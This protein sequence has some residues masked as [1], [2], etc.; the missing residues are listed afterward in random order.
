MNSWIASFDVDRTRFQSVAVMC[1][2]RLRKVG[3]Q[4]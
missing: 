3:G 1:E 2:Q 4:Q